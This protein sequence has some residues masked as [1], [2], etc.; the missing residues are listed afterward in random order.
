MNVIKTNQNLIIDGMI[1][2]MS[3]TPL[4]YIFSGALFSFSIMFSVILLPPYIISL[5]IILKRR[6]IGEK[7]NKVTYQVIE[8]ICF[9]IAIT[10]IVLISDYNLQTI[11]ERIRYV[12]L[13]S[14]ISVIIWW[15]LLKII[16]SK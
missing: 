8:L 5:G 16:R 13:F 1:L 11:I 9:L 7:S 12:S 6:V 14:F 2:G 15:V 3:T 4:I 10:F